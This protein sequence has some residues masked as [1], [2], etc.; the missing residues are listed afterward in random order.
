MKSLLSKYGCVLPVTYKYELTELYIT[1]IQNR[2]N[3][4]AGPG[5]SHNRRPSVDKYLYCIQCTTDPII[6]L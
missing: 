1:K 3:V 5:Q 6:C 2:I 4:F